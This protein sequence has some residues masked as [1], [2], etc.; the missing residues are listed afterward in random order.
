MIGRT[1]PAW[2]IRQVAASSFQ[3][4]EL[5]IINRA[6]A[7]KQFFASAASI[8]FASTCLAS[9]LP[10]ANLT[11]GATSG[12][13]TQE[14]ISSTVCVRGYTKTVRPPAYYTN[15]LKKLQIEQYGYADRDPKHY[16]EDHLIALSIGGDPT[17]PRNLWP[18]PRSTAWSAAK[19]D[20]LEFVLYKMVCNGD[21]SIAK[22][23][24]Q[25]A[26]DWIAAALA[27]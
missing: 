21:I 26:T 2:L 10:K 14:N 23:Q 16:E 22:A 17:D 11:P 18:Q 15:K 12:V 25:M 5:F 1:A 19:K 24:Q 13:V 27:A 3:G 4:S 6:S 8:F 9:D 7:I 20:N